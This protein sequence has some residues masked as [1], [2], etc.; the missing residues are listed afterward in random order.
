MQQFNDPQANDRRVGT[1]EV[2]L[3]LPIGRASIVR[4]SGSQPLDVS[5]C[6][7]EYRVNLSLTPR[8]RN[9]GVCFSEKWAAHEFKPIGSLY[10]LP[11]GQAVRA[12]GDCSPHASIVCEFAPATI[13]AWFDGDVRWTNRRLEAMLD[14]DNPNMRS[15]LRRLSEEMRNPGLA[16]A[17]ICELLAAQVA[18]ESARHCS[19]VQ[20]VKNRGGLPVWKLKLIDDRLA[21]IG[22]APT[23][24]ELAALCNVSVRQLTRGFRASRGR[25]IGEHM[26]QNRLAHATRLLAGDQSIKTIAYALGFPSPSGFCAAFRR[27]TGMTP[28][29]FR[30]SITRSA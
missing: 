14:I 25:S 13:D 11:P 4:F 5:G 22:S 15:S 20:E 30:T 24:S 16:S 18:I 2:E 1:T 7:A 19:A 21:E 28:S 3:R 12:R 10:V 27:D 17:A 29:E 23:L 6:P 26:V 9:G 8:A